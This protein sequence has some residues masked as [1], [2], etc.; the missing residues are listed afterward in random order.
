M[1][2]NSCAKCGACTSV[3]P[4]YQV[5]GQEAFTARG[6]LHLLEKI[7]DDKRSQTYLDIFSKC[8][9]CGACHKACPRNINIVNKVVEN[10]RNFPNS[11]GN[12]SLARSMVKGCLSHEV[13]LASIGKLLKIS[14][15]L[16]NKLPMASGLRLKLGLPPT[17]SHQIISGPEKTNLE[18][19]HQDSSPD[20]MLFPGCFAR[21]LNPEIISSTSKLLSD[22]TS[23][24]PALPA[25]QSCCG[26]AFYSSGDIEKA[27]QLARLNIAAF[28]DTTLPIVVLCGSCYSHLKDYPDLLAD[29]PEYHSKSITFSERLQEMSSYLA[30]Q[31]IPSDNAKDEYHKSG[32]KRVIYHDPCHLRFSHELK[33][34]PRQLLNNLPGIKL[35]ELPDGPRCCGFGGLFNLSHPDISEKIA[36]K[37]VQE[38]M[39]INPDLLV[40]TCSGCL[41]QIQ[42]QLALSGSKTKV[43]H[44]AQILSDLE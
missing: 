27:R 17:A 1:T 15:P 33:E 16:I 20:L 31:L 34:S 26:L 44:L 9:L 2:D 25:A 35:I 11:S 30:D 18:Q 41:I 19:S 3:C 40:T 10:R 38:I 37:L 39:T 23:L 36:G 28:D 29:D 21:H 4:I 7:T 5:S 24:I 13:I 6:R 8:L 12:G 22:K 14:T 43:Y 32:T 42:Q